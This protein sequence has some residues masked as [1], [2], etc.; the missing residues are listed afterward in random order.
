MTRAELQTQVREMLMEALASSCDKLI[1][2]LPEEALND[3]NAGEFILSTFRSI[4][5]AMAQQSKDVTVTLAEAVK[6]YYKG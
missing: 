1:Q 6:K 5:D 3:P 2:A 4:S